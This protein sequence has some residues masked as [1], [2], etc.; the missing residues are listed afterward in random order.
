MCLRHTAVQNSLK[1]GGLVVSKRAAAESVYETLRHNQSSG[2][3][4]TAAAV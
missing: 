1:N 3:V 2:D 4:Y